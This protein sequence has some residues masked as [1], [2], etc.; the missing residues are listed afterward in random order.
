MIFFLQTK[1]ACAWT[2]INTKIRQY[3]V[4]GNETKWKADNVSTKDDALYK[5][6]L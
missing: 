6:K 3:T 4:Q 5:N 1:D 2:I